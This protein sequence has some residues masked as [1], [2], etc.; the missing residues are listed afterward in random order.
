[1]ASVQAVRQYRFGGPEVLAVEEVADLEPPVGQVRIA[2]SAAGVHL[3][4]LSMRAGEAGGPFPVPHLPMTPGR[5]VAGVVDAVGAEVD[6]SWIGQ[7]VVA[8]LGAA[9][10]GY[11]AQA[12]APVETLIRLAPDVDSAEAVAMVG[13]GRTALAVLEEANLDH[14]DVVVVTAAAGGIG[15]LLVQ[16]ARRAGALTVGVAG[17]ASKV[18]VVESL[19]ADVAVDYLDADWPSHVTAILGQRRVTAALDG[20][21]GAIGRAAFELVAPRGR[22]VMFGYSSGDTIQ[23]GADDLFASGVDVVAAVGPRLF[24][25]PGGLRPLAEEALA[26]LAA[27]SWRPL[28][29]PFPL[30]EVARAHRAVADRT[31]IGKV[32]LTV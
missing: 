2:V 9:G 3:L 16:A 15:S 8:H 29:S 13:T 18:A 32:V 5:E 1:M 14:D 21:G 20:V 27:H 22:L 11:A 6:R 31:T 17:G 25:R 10:G 30:N 4:D 23:L 12:V 26:G 28:I 24:A 19:G 7:S